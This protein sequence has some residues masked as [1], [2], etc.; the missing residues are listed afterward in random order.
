MEMLN[1]RQLRFI[2]EYVIDHNASRAAR[3]AGYARRGAGV[4]ECQLSLSS[5]IH[6]KFA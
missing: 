1:S 5:S 4:R 3:D 6:V 2:D